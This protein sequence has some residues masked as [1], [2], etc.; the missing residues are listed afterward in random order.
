MRSRS[1]APLRPEGPQLVA[2]VREGVDEKALRARSEEDAEH[3]VWKNEVSALRA[4]RDG[5]GFFH[6]PHGPGLLSTGPFGSKKLR[7]IQCSW[8]PNSADD[9]MKSKT[10]FVDLGHAETSS[11]PSL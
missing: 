7:L 11:L 1:W 5:G 6:A 3:F 2:T 9:P 8:T 4:W 10:D